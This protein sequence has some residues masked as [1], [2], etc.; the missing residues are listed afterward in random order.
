[1]KRYKDKLEER[2][3]YFN[4]KIVEFLADDL[5]FW[6]KKNDPQKAGKELASIIRDIIDELA[7]DL[8]VPMGT[9]T[10]FINNLKQNL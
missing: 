4:P 9:K 7:L 2:S 5:T 8:E 6:F 3:Y 1:M 10:K